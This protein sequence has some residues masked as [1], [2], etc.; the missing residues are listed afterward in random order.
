MLSVWFCGSS[1]KNILADW[2]EN[3][4][5]LGFADNPANIS[6]IPFPTV[7]TALNH[8]EKL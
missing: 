2:H 1:I 5:T 4:M 8:E 3:P 6:M 7:S